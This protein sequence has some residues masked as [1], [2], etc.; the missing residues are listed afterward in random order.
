MAA[1][2]SECRKTSFN[3]Y[4]N[5]DPAFNAH[6]YKTSSAALNDKYFSMNT[7]QMLKDV[8]NFSQFGSSSNVTFGNNQAQQQTNDTDNMFSADTAKT[9][10]FKRY[11]FRMLRY[12]NCSIEMTNCHF[13]HQVNIIILYIK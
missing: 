1:Y 13:S 2:A 4:G 6:F 7:A 9:L 8:D 10:F 12:G 3:T 11:C 5:N